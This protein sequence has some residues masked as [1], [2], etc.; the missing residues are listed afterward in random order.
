MGRGSVPSWQHPG[1]RD[2]VAAGA[3]VGPKHHQHLPCPAK[4]H[5][6]HPCPPRSRVPSADLCTAQLTAPAHGRS[7]QGLSTGRPTGQ[8]SLQ[9]LRT[10][11]KEP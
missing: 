5:N 7:R 11:R 4:K 1:H 10:L 8:G 2:S 6:L 9:G 3:E